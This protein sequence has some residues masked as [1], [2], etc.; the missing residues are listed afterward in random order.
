VL[1]E[2]LPVNVCCADVGA[3]IAMAIASHEN[4]KT[5]KRLIWFRAFVLSWL[6]TAASNARLVLLDGAQ[7]L[8]QRHGTR[9][10]E[11]HGRL[12]AE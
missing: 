8:E 9:V 4:T 5:R 7:F 1:S 12:E 10:R 2:S 3:T 11:L 6:I